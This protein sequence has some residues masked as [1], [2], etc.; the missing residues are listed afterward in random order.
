MFLH[1]TSEETGR[2]GPRQP[3]YSSTCLITA[4]Q[5]G[6]ISKALKQK[7]KLYILGMFQSKE[8]F[9]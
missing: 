4:P 2:T 6:P 5:K 8:N 7:V 1:D 3:E 9:P